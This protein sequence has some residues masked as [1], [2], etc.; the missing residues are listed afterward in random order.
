M[1]SAPVAGTPG[2]NHVLVT[3]RAVGTAG[4]HGSTTLANVAVDASGVSRAATPIAT[5][6]ATVTTSI[7]MRRTITPDPRA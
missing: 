6:A 2:Q 3:A 1:P 7:G 5:A 4:I